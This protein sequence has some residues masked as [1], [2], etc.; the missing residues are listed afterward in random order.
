MAVQ[1]SPCYID[2]FCS[3]SQFIDFNLL[4]LYKCPCFDSILR[5]YD[6]VSK[7]VGCGDVAGVGYSSLLHSNW[8]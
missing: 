2:Y 5:I 6:I 1:G 7:V 4:S 8:L 3:A